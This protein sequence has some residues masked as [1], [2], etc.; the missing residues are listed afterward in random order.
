MEL[1]M[2]RRST[3]VDEDISGSAGSLSKLGVIATT[4]NKVETCSRSEERAKKKPKFN[5][6]AIPI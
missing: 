2:R 1:A 4:I 6:E 3:E 5:L